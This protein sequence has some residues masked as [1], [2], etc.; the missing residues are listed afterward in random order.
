MV[1]SWFEPALKRALQYCRLPLQM[2]YFR[3]TVTYVHMGIAVPNLVSDLCYCQNLL[4]FFPN[5]TLLTTKYH[6]IKP[7]DIF[8]NESFHSWWDLCH[9]FRWP[10]INPSSFV[11]KTQV[12][13]N[14][15]IFLIW[16]SNDFKYF[17]IVTI[18]L[19]KLWQL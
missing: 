17:T 9:L 18:S 12:V 15:A 16:H 6:C 5:R 3:F 7:N 2:I 8:S 1:Y 4:A 19:S 11:F 14:V 13:A 10:Q